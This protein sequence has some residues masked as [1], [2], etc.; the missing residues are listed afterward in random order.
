MPGTDHRVKDGDEKAGRNKE[1]PGEGV[2]A[3][4]RVPLKQVRKATKI[5]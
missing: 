4:A 1:G 2:H 5:E 3:M